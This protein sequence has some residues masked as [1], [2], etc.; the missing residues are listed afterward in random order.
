MQ[1]NYIELIDENGVILYRGTDASDIDS[2]HS[3]FYDILNKQHVTYSKKDI[4]GKRIFTY[5]A[6]ERTLDIIEKIQGDDELTPAEKQRLFQIPGLYKE[7]VNVKLLKLLKIN[8]YK[9]IDDIPLEILLTAITG[10]IDVAFKHANDILDKLLV[11]EKDSTIVL[12]INTTKNDLKTNVED[13]YKH[14]LSTITKD[15]FFGK[16]PT[17]LNPLPLQEIL[18]I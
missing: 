18:A 14:E 2:E 15:N 16:W 12:E 4:A 7:Y 10:L 8:N 6:Y 17:L 3:M 11:D 1:N 5:Q 13:F 9:S